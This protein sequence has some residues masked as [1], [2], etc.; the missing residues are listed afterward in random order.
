MDQVMCTAK[1]D[2]MAVM[3]AMSHAPLVPRQQARDQHPKATV[4]C[5]SISRCHPSGEALCHSILINNIC[6]I[7]SSNS[8]LSS[9]I[10]RRRRRN[11]KGLQLWPNIRTRRPNNTHPYRDIILP[12]LYLLTPNHIITRPIE[13]CRGWVMRLNH[14]LANMLPRR[15]MEYITLTCT[16]LIVQHNKGQ[17][18]NGNAP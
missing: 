5:S 1:T 16:T 11:S 18:H 12:L 17:R 2:R 9:L 14:C 4:K 10:R 15:K 8:N 6:I 13:R 7:N 3:I